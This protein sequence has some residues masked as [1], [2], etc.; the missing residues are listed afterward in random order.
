[1]LRILRCA[2]INR[3]GAAPAASCQAAVRTASA[4]GQSREATPYRQQAQGGG[5]HLGAPM[6]IK[7]AWSPKPWPA[8][9]TGGAPR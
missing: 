6:A 7:A 9:A 1:V 2:G 4:S 5:L 3:G 8:C